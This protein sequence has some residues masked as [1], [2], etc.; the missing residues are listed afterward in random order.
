MSKK[1]V[2]TNIGSYVFDASA[3]TITV[4]GIPALTLEQFLV[5]T[6]VTTNTIIY[7]FASS[8]LGGTLLGSVLTLDY[9]TL[10]MSD[11]DDLQI[12]IWDN[13][14]DQVNMSISIPLPPDA[15]TESTQQLVKEDL[16]KFQFDGSG[17]L[18]VNVELGTV[19]AVQIKNA[20]DILINP[21]KED[22]NLAT[23]KTNTD[24]LDVNLSTRLA[25]NTFTGRVG[26]VQAAPT[27]YT[28]LGR[29]KD[30]VTQLATTLAV[31]VTSFLGTTLGQ[32]TM[33]NSLPVV[34]P[35][36][37][38]AIPV[39][40]AG[41]WTVGVSV[42][43]VQLKDGAGTVIN[44]AK[45]DGNLATVKTN[46]DKLDVNL[47]TR[48]AENTFT[49]RIPTLGQKTM[50][51]AAP[52]VIASDQSAIPTSQSGTWTVG[53][54]GTVPIS[55]SALPLPSGASTETTLSAL[56][57]KIGEVQAAPTQY[58][59]LGRLKDIVTQ[60]ATTLAVNVTSFLGMS[61]GQKTMANSLPVVLSSD[62]ALPLPTGASTETTLSAINTKTLTAGQK[63]MA[64]SS[65][66]VIASDQSA[67]PISA[68]ALPLPTGAST[69]T[70]LSAINTK[71]PTNGQ[72]TMANSLPVVL[73]SDQ[74]ITISGNSDSNL[75]CL[76]YENLSGIGLLAASMWRRG[77]TY[78][79]PSGYSMRISKFMSMSSLNTSQSRLVK[80]IY[81]GSYN[82][83]TSTFTD[84]SAYSIPSFA[85]KVVG[86]VSTI[87]GSSPPNITVNYTNQ[88]GTTGHAT[89]TRNFAANTPVD[90]QFEFTLQNGD[91]GIIDITS[92]TRNSG[93]TGVIQFWGVTEVFFHAN[94]TAYAYKTE[95]INDK[96]IIPYGCS[97]ALEFS[98]SV[99][100]SAQRY[101]KALFT[102][103]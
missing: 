60:L 53:I 103:F 46:T 20:S 5:I 102:L 8:G 18:K 76:S 82:I 13:S 86:I 62:Q 32:K 52:V 93:N 48:L 1:I 65:P 43:A 79:V 90:S 17:N 83:A 15:S 85:N 24:K 63:T 55:A 97:V 2:G 6:N 44:P 95:I 100:S 96:V 34:L 11:T 101:L 50:V 58:T 10:S 59:L 81:L 72:K 49:A 98:G 57:T 12:F 91:F 89:N 56:N 35:S 66:V 69:E 80:L 94:D 9:S 21:A 4:Y 64:N 42:S 87:I 29:L 16:D 45:E 54:S 61:L 30:I 23:I 28:L 70:T 92:I 37:Q 33:V 26:E 84:G 71:I 19:E 38:S 3:K 22:G 67:I 88:D 40:Q 36:D 75:N 25:E 51:N 99:S 73:P 39:S 78:T 74:T 41:T 77:I 47:S 31:N 7:N 27:Q 68:S 14:P